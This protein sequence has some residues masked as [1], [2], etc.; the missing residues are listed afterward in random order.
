M[1]TLTFGQTRRHQY[2]PKNSSR[3]TT[4]GRQTTPNPHRDGSAFSTDST[5]MTESRSANDPDN[6]PNAADNQAQVDA[7]RTQRAMIFWAI[8]STCGLVLYGGFG[9]FLLQSVASPHTHVN[10]FIDLAVTGLTIGA[11]TKP[12]HDLV[13]SVQTKAAGST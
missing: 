7:R 1:N 8:A 3:S 5:T 10:S 2:T 13:T 9:F 12:L 4:Y 6:F 11:G